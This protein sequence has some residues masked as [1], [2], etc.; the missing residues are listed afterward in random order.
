MLHSW[1]WPIGIERRN[2]T[3]NDIRQIACDQ[4]KAVEAGSCGDACVIDVL[5]ARP[6]QR[7][8]KL[9]GVPTAESMAISL[10]EVR[11]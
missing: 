5:L 7:S 11:R 10:E 4:Y 8:P 1:R 2:A 6:E 9:G 3:R